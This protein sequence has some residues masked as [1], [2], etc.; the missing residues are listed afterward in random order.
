MIVLLDGPQLMERVQQFPENFKFFLN[1]GFN[2]TLQGGERGTASSLQLSTQLR[3][4]IIS[5]SSAE[6][7]RQINAATATF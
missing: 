4:T 3:Q 5:N 7:I 2:V 1:D 6:A